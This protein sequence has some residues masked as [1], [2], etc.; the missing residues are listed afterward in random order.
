MF[1]LEHY[2]VGQT[3]LISE[4]KDHLEQQPHLFAELGRPNQVAIRNE[5][6]M[7]D[8]VAEFHLEEDKATCIFNI[9]DESTCSH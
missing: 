4:V 9:Y 7:D 8:V 1:S 3:Y 2:K 6:C 5:N